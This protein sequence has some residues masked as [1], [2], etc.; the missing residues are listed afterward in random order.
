MSARFVSRRIVCWRHGQT[1]WNAERRF[2]GHTDVP[3]NEVGRR[4]ADHA[5]EL[6][7]RL[8]PE[9]IVSSDLSRASATATALARRTGLEV[10]YDKRLRERFGGAWEGLTR[11]EIR[12]QWPEHHDR[13]EIPDGEDLQTVGDRVTEAVRRAVAD[14]PESGTLV[15]VSHGAALRAGITQ[16]LGLAPQSLRMLGPIGNCAWSVLEPRSGGDWC[17]VEHNAASLP[18]ARVLS[19]DQQ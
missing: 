2:Q 13:W 9:A 11:A 12:E 10:S 3:L 14:C 19:D 15:V 5:A 16:L 6:L 4:Q 17:L 8:R 1:E 18:E 7:V